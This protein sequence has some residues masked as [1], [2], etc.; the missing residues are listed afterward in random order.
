MIN[1]AKNR[2][3]VKSLADREA[4]REA[5]P[6]GAHICEWR[7][8]I[9]RRRHQRHWQLNQRIGAQQPPALQCVGATAAGA[10]PSFRSF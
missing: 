4:L 9:Q 1:I 7:R 6:R 10:L 5:L 3:A 8:S 2:P